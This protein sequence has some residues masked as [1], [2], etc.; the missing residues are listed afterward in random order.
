MSLLKDIMRIRGFEEDFLHP[1]Y[2]NFPDQLPDIEKAADRILQAA[3]D[4]EKVLIYGDYDADGI[5]ASTLMFEALKLSGLKTVEIM[6][7]NRFKDGYGMSRRLIEHATTQGVNLV[8]T[9]DCGSNN[10][11]IIKELKSAGIDTVVT[12]HHECSGALPSAVAIVNPKHPQ[13]TVAT[14]LQHLAGVGVAF[15]VVYQL[16]LRGAIPEGQEKWLLDLVLIGTICDSM[17]LTGLN[18]ALCYYGLKV[19]SRT[20]RPG[21]KEL[22]FRAQVNQINS[23]VVSFQIGPRINAAGRMQSADLALQLVQASSRVQAAKLAEELENLNQFRKSEQNRAITEI[24]Q[25]GVSDDPVLVEMGNWHEGVLGIIAGRLTEE[26]QRPAFALSQVGDVVKGSGRSF[27][28]FNLAKALSACK[29]QIIGGGGHAGACGL[30]LSPTSIDD[31]RQS[32]NDYYRGLNLSDQSKYLSVPADLQLTDFS[33]ISV[34]A[35]TELSQLEPYGEGNP[36]PV[37]KLS[38]KISNLRRMGDHKQ[39]LKIDLSDQAGHVLP[40]VG[41]SAPDAWQK[42]AIGQK[43]D[44]SVHLM[45]NEWH[46]IKSVEGRII[47]LTE[48]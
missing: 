18:R 21:L 1:N 26:Y 15:L 14:D 17:V 28:D 40:I 32:V 46:G 20:R 23:E 7:P 10:A 4:Q 25:R 34:P 31:F 44:A 47:A 2:G 27:G 6:L 41:F 13:A 12:D 39:H 9:V 43:V 3:I 36:E 48:G 8:I 11:D 45:V 5:T 24:S 16:M 22:M 38:G 37:F 35:V 29:K 30:K 42:I 19:L 33:A